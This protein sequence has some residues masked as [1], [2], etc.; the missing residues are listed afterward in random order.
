M[1]GKRSTCRPAILPRKSRTGG[2]YFTS[3]HACWLW[4]GDGS[5]LPKLYKGEKVLFGTD[6]GWRI[7]EYAYGAGEWGCYGSGCCSTVDGKW[8]KEEQECS[9]GKGTWM[10]F[11]EEVADEG[12]GI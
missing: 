7:A 12:E 11:K 9:E 10:D 3:S 6:G 4:R 8:H 1:L 2:A 5:G